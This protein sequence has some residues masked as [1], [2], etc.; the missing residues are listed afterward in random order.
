MPLAFYSLSQH[1]A[2]MS[3]SK[4]SVPV[5]ATLPTFYPAGLEE[6]K[7]E[8]KHLSFSSCRLISHCP[9]LGPMDYLLAIG[10]GNVFFVVV[11]VFFFNQL[12][13]VPSL[14]L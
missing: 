13:P 3:K 4:T 8:G 14:K 11:F 9:E 5:P 10:L 7:G 2:F 6:G 12:S 1:V